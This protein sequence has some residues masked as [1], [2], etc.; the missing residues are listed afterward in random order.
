M[1]VPRIDASPG[2]APSSVSRDLFLDLSLEGQ[3]Q[4]P[5]NLFLPLKNPRQM[6]ALLGLLQSAAGDVH[7][8]LASLHYV[9][10]AR[11]LPSPDGSVLMVITEYDGGLESYIMD[12]VG[13]LGEQFTQILQYIAG[14]PPLPVKR[15][16]REFTQFILDHNVGQTGVWSAYPNVTVIDILHGAQR[17]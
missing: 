6:P 10:F 12:F 2:N 9:H 3:V 16:A 11:F 1:H 17:L 15:Y 4:H 14:A 13:V 7:E 5:L 8:A